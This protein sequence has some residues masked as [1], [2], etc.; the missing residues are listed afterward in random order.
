MMNNTLH[1]MRKKV[2]NQ[3]LFSRAEGK[4]KLNQVIL[5]QRSLCVGEGFFLRN[6]PLNEVCCQ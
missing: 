4:T 2:F 6:W 5:C 3:Y 1:F